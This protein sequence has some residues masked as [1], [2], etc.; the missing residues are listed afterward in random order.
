MLKVPVLVLAFNRAKHVKEVMVAIQKYQPDK[1]Y[2]ACD[3]PRPN[4]VADIAA[5]KETQKA[6]L[7]AV[8]WPC[9]VRTLFR[10]ENLGCANAVN[11]AI[12]WFFQNEEFGIICEDDIILGFDFFLLC[13]DLLPRYADQEQIMEIVSQN[14]SYR[15]DISNTYV[16]S[17]RE[18]CWGWAS[19]RRAWEKMDM[20]MSS[21]PHMTYSKLFK[22]LGFFEGLMKKH[23]YMAGYRNLK[24]F[25]SWA[26]R[27]NLSIL[28]NNGLVI[29]PGVNLSKNIGIDGGTHYE[30]GDK[31]PYERL[32]IGN[33]DWPLI[34]NDSL[35]IDKTQASADKK[36]FLRIR[37]IGVR[38][39]I[40]KI[41]FKRLGI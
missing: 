34:Y 3:G 15:K 22:K 13:E 26:T 36:D 16:Y 30:T 18:H 12:S 25:N 14:H 17:Y 9:E 40:N 31:D 39:K 33:I 6:M 23:Y 38:K 29:I 8:D 21:A 32:E 7:D 4:N 37:M 20:S 41:L 24:N 28:A 19:W 35:I 10:K 2:L 27:W 5:V 1:L 11:D